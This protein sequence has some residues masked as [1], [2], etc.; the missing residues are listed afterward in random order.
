MFR[1]SAIFDLIECAPFCIW[2]R[3]VCW[4]C[5]VAAVFKGDQGL[6]NCVRHTRQPVLEDAVLSDWPTFDKFHSR[7]VDRLRFC[8]AVKTESET[9][10]HVGGIPLGGAG[11]CSECTSEHQR[12]KAERHFVPESE[13]HML[14]VLKKIAWEI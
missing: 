7:R 10:D 11:L 14:S 12:E 3:V 13:E 2:S 6:V 9:A 4:Q 8:V 1:N 5:D